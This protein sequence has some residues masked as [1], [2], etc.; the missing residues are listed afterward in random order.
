MKFTG[1]RSLFRG[2][3][4]IDTVYSLTPWDIIELTQSKSQGWCM[5]MSIH[6]ILSKCPIQRVS[7]FQ[8]LLGNRRQYVP[9]RPFFGG[10]GS[11]LDAYSYEIYDHLVIFFVQTG[12]EFLAEER[13]FL[14]QPP[15]NLTYIEY[16]QYCYD[17][18]WTLAYALNK[19][20]KSNSVL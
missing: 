16:S 13:K 4:S 5:G 8:M 19:T 6:N 10:L 17:A 1:A 2:F 18:T 12:G 7:S 11:R 20:L 3:T 14:G 15:L 9:W